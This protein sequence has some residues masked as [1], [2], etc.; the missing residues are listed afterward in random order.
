MAVYKGFPSLKNGLI[1][2]FVQNW[3]TG[4]IAAKSVKTGNPLAAPVLINRQYL[5]Q[6]LHREFLDNQMKRMPYIMPARELPFSLIVC[7]LSLQCKSLL[8]FILTK[9][10]YFVRRTLHIK[11][12][13]P[14]I[15]WINKV[16]IRLFQRLKAAAPATI[17]K[18]Q[19]DWNRFR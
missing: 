15:K 11:R 5:A 7:S 12:G 3:D 2:R 14:L 9:K 1:Y 8:T 19:N 6:K 16:E 17:G 13:S 18:C 10:I 4:L